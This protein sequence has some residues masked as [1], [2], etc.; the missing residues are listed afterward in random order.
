MTL[1]SPLRSSQGWYLR[2]CTAG[3]SPTPATA[4]KQRGFWWLRDKLYSNL[5][6]S[7]T[8]CLFHLLVLKTGVTKLL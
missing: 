7:L 1:K 6:E 8:L 2:E 4:E 3:K 5:G